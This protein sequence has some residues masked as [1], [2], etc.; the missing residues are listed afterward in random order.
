M[1]D[2]GKISVGRVQAPAVWLAVEKE[3]E[4]RNFVPAK[5]WVV[6][7]MLDKSGIGFKAFHKNGSFSDETAAKTAFA[8]VSSAKTAQITKVETKE[9]RQNPKPPFSTVELQVTAN[10]QLKIAPERTMAIAQE[11]FEHGLISYHRTDT[12]RIADEFI[13]E[14][15]VHVGANIGPAY[16]PAT[17]NSY[18]SAHSQAD[19]H[20]AIRPT[21]M[22]SHGE[23]SQIMAT[24][25]LGPDHYKLY[26]LIY[27]RTV[28]SQMASAVFD[29]TTVAIE[30]AGEPFKSTGRVLKFDGFL[31]VYSENKDEDDTGDDDQKLPKLTDGEAVDKVDQKNESKQTKPPGRYNEGT[32]VKALEKHGIGRPSTYASIMGTIKS[33]TYIQIL[34]DKVHAS[35]LGE[36]LFDYLAAEHGWVV[37]LTLTKTMEEYLDKVESQTGTWELFAK[38]LHAKMAFAAPPTRSGAGGADREPSPKSLNY[39]NSIS[40]KFG[41][42]LPPDCL[43]SHNALSV[44][45]DANKGEAGP[46]GGAATDHAPSEKQVALVASLCT[47]KGLALPKTHLT[48]SLDNSA[49]INGILGKGTGSPA[50]K[51][52]STGHPAKPVSGAKSTKSG[53]AAGSASKSKKAAVKK[54]A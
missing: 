47:K 37:D 38:G 46:A 49:F 21:H 51:S 2:G 39:G 16:L 44:W 41:I 42:P 43:T 19:A 12:T 26:E 10:I 15:R 18:V 28:A 53:T 7:I 40:K 27:K 20:E 1:T 23:I 35:P 45:I 5:F 36:L 14:I 13:E 31:V 24:E 6:T 8:A 9:T 30:C 11:L 29:A 52:P 34:K 17:P 4:I 50:G 25:G 22:H 32:L 54:A 3:R 33:R 48:S